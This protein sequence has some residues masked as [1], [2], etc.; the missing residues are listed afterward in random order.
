METLQDTDL[1]TLEKLGSKGY[2]DAYLQAQVRTW[3]AY[4]FQALRKNFD[5]SQAEMAE[6]TGMTKNMISR[7]E[8]EECGEVSVQ[9]LLDVA[10]AMD[11][12]LVVKF[13]SY[14]DFLES[15]RDKSESGMQPN[16]LM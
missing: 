7:L 3:I 5:L 11:V 14:P 9:T 15:T 13:A 12:A 16:Q 8:S 10:C 2:R 4:Q 1:K 6:R